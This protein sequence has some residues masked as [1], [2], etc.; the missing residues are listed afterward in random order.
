M[1]TVTG[2]NAL[3]LAVAG[4]HQNVLSQDLPRL[5]VF[6]DRSPIGVDPQVQVQQLHTSITRIHGILVLSACWTCRAGSISFNHQAAANVRRPSMP[7]LCQF[8]SHTLH[9]FI[10]LPLMGGFCNLP[11]DLQKQRC[12]G[13]N[14]LLQP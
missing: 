1:G 11:T 10:M 12:F 3:H 13:C 8:K 9:L 2:W 14:P 4:K 7:W 6:V 5:A